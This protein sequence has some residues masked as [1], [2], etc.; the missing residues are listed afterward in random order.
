MKR[1]SK[2]RTRPEPSPLPEPPE[3]YQPTKAELEEEFDMPGLS[4]EQARE[5]FMRPFRHLYPASKSRQ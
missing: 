1:P 5:F 2:P 3:G 4:L